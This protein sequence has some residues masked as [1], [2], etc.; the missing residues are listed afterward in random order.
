MGQ[1]VTANETGE[2]EDKVVNNIHPDTF[3]PISNSSIIVTK[4]QNET[5]PDQIAWPESG[6]G[7]N[8]SHPRKRNLYNFYLLS[9]SKF[10][11]TISCFFQ[12]RVTAL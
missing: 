4:P 6:S 5:E 7:V 2:E 3:D 9:L 10:H 1:S 8:A 11:L 12:N